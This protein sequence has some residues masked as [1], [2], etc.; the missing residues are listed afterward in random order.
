VTSGSSLNLPIG[1]R[2]SA[3]ESL[4]SLVEFSAYRR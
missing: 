3:M 4:L 1:Y 2:R